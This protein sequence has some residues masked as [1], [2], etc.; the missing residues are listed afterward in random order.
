MTFMLDEDDELPR[1]ESGMKV[2]AKNGRVWIKYLPEER[3]NHV[4]TLTAEE[5]RALATA[6]ENYAD[7]N[8]EDNDEYYQ[9]SMLRSSADKAEEQGD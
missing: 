5:A 1:G 4:K 3:D 9:A 6:H 7:N 2:W 8:G